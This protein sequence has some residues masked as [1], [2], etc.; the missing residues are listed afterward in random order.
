MFIKISQVFE[1]TCFIFLHI[2]TRC[3]IGL[4]QFYSAFKMTF[5]FSCDQIFFANLSIKS[6]ILFFCSCGLFYFFTGLTKCY[7]LLVYFSSVMG[8][9]KFLAYNTFLFENKLISWRWWFNGI[10]IYCSS[11]RKS[12]WTNWAWNSKTKRCIR[13]RKIENLRRSLTGITPSRTIGFNDLVY[14]SC[15]S[16]FSVSFFIDFCLDASILLGTRS[17]SDLG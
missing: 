10:K 4:Y 9:L 1:I 2:V 15:R 13:S 3:F 12:G 16:I 8:Y 11:G 7:W 14:R 6:S 5:K 17:M